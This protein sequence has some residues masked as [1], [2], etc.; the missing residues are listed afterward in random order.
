MFNSRNSANIT[1]YQSYMKTTDTS[2]SV[3][4]KIYNNKIEN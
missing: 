2:V 4:I 3:I 1:H